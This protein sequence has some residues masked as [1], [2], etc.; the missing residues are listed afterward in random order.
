MT[1]NGKVYLVGAGPGDPGLITVKGLRCLQRADLV[2]YDGLVN[3]LL[4]RLS[5]AQIERTSRIKSGQVDGQAEI[6]RRLIEA[7]RSGK[8]VVRL[9]GGDPFIFGRG[10]EEAAALAEAG[11]EFEV[12]PGVT[13]AVAAGEYAGLSFTHRDYASAVAFVTGHEDPA[14]EQP[15]I[16]YAAIARFPGTLVFYMGLHRL[17]S[18]VDALL[19]G[20]KPATTPACVVGSA[21]NPSQRTI[22]APLGQLAEAVRSA[23]LHPPS[24]IVVGECVS[25]R[26]AIAWFEKRP[27]FGRRIGITRPAAQAGP[28]IERVLELGAEPVLL[29]T[30][31][32]LPPDDWT[33]IDAALARL[34]EFDW[35]VFT[36]VNGVEAL[37]GR[38]WEQGGDARRLGGLRIAAIGPAT[39]ESLRRFGLRP[40]LV[41]PA[42]RAE[43]LAA[44]LRPHVSGKRVLWARADRGREVLPQELTKAGAA[45]EPLVVYRNVDLSE[46]PPGQLSRLERG[47]LDWIALGS[48]SIAESLHALCTPA[49]RKQLG[50]RTRL[51]S[52]SPVT[53]ARAQQLGLAI[54]AEATEYTWDGLLD[55]IVEAEASLTPN[56]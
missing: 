41:P 49:A 7:A 47:E 10:S 12:V 36:S 21:T 56:P 52:I 14:K 8:T 32:I 26:E 16:D 53:T 35:L 4:L 48:P 42:Y 23:D 11:I 25:R 19:R 38:L 17:E 22:A 5:S 24:I 20:G 43:S 6:N 31:E 30:I 9:K 37:L 27:L 46:L 40:D 3:P 44:E 34:N 55:A 15:A 1:S 54:A 51:A 29:P 39:G 50:Q 33:P 28:A 45:I 2:L 18:L 13:A